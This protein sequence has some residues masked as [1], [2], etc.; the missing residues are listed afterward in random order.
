MSIS[1]GVESVTF[2]ETAARSVGKLHRLA[3]VL[4]IVDLIWLR[5]ARAGARIRVIG[6]ERERRIWAPGASILTAYSPISKAS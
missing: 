1:K 4:S 6:G 2:Y 3:T 5:V